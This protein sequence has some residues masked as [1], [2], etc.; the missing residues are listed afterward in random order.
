MCVWKRRLPRPRELA[1]IIFLSTRRRG[2]PGFNSHTVPGEVSQV[3]IYSQ[4]KTAKR[5]VMGKDRVIIQRG[6]KKERGGQWEKR[7][8]PIHEEM[9]DCEKRKRKKRKE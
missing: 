7:Q 6:G 1:L 3:G 8:N 4:G 5:K 2:G 9:G